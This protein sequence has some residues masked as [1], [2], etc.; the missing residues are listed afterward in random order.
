MS[1]KDIKYKVTFLATTHP[2]FLTLFRSSPPE[3]SGCTTITYKTNTLKLH[4]TVMCVALTTPNAYSP[5]QQRI[6]IPKTCGAL[7]LGGLFSFSL[8]FLDKQKE[9]ER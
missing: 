5:Q 6:A 1:Y 8:S 7:V 9:R 4:S 3:V 2:N